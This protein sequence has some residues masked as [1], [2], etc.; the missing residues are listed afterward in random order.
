MNALVIGGVSPDEDSVFRQPDLLAAPTTDGSVRVPGKIVYPSAAAAVAEL[1]RLIGDISLLN[2]QRSDLDRRIG[3]LRER[4]ADPANFEHP[5]RAEAEQ[6]HEDLVIDRAAMEARLQGSML[7]AGD[8]F[9]ALPDAT[10]SKLAA[11]GW[12]PVR[13]RNAMR[14]WLESCLAT[15]SLPG[16]EPPF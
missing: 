12:P 4:L 7:L 5:R 10:R 16:E 3:H 1:L 2:R 15:G 6:R 9:L 8:I 11:E 14:I 13:T